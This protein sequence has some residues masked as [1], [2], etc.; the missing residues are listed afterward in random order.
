MQQFTVYQALT[1][2]WDELNSMLERNRNNDN[3]YDSK[4]KLTNERYHLLQINLFSM[5]IP[6]LSFFT[7]IIEIFFAPH[8]FIESIFML[9]QTLNLILLNCIN[10]SWTY[11]NC[12]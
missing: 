8:T 3:R 2:S 9:E 5:G 7:Q 10:L 6:H 1:G 11:I 4:L 12:K